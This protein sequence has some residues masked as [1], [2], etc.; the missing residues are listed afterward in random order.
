MPV[1]IIRWFAIESVVI[2]LYWLILFIYPLKHIISKNQNTDEMV[3]FA[4]LIIFL[5]K[6]KF[7]SI[8]FFFWER[9]K[10]GEGRE[11]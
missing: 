9:G 4:S 10:E 6:K 2:P 5:L 11:V 7:C 3:F 1:F 8:L